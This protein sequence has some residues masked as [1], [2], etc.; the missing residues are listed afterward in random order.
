MVTRSADSPSLESMQMIDKRTQQIILTKP[1]K[2]HAG[3]IQHIE[4]KNM[5]AGFYDIQ[6]ICNG[7]TIHRLTCIKFFPLVVIMNACNGNYT[8]MK[9]VY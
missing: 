6:M 1:I 8:T 3:Q 5:T 4:L 9:T 7:D 2:N